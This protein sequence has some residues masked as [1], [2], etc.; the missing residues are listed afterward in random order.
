MAD[1]MGLGRKR[2]VIDCAM[3]LIITNNINQLSFKARNELK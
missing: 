2:V 3:I 1:E